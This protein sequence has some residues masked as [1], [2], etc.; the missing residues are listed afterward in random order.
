MLVPT[1]VHAARLLLLVRPPTGGVSV[2]A[3]A[4]PPKPGA[5]ALGSVRR[6]GSNSGKHTGAAKALPW[7]A[8]A[9]GLA[10][11]AGLIYQA[12][13]PAEHGAAPTPTP[14]PS[15]NPS[16]NPNMT[17]ARGL[18]PASQDTTQPSQDTP[19]APA[20]AALGTGA[21]SGTA[22]TSALANAGITRPYI[23]VAVP[24][25]S[26]QP[27]PAPA[28]TRR[29]AAPVRPFQ[30]VSDPLK[31][32]Q[33]AA[34]AQAAQAMTAAPAAPQAKRLGF[35]L[36][37]GAPAAPQAA[38]APPVPQPAAT[39]AQ[40][41]APGF[42]A[43]TPAPAAAAPAAQ[44]ISPP[45]GFAGQELTQAPVGMGERFMAGL[46]QGFGG[47]LL[48]G[49]TDYLNTHRVPDVQP[50]DPGTGQ[51]IP[52][53][54]PRQQVQ[55]SITEQRARDADM[56]AWGAGG[57]STLGTIGNAAAGTAGTVLGTLATPETVLGAGLARSAAASGGAA[58][59]TGTAARQSWGVPA[60]VQP[61]KWGQALVP[62]FMA[63]TLRASP[64]VPGWLTPSALAQ[65]IGAAGAVNTAHGAGQAIDTNALK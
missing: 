27:A 18:V 60:W 36:D 42:G 2:P 25:P 30:P 23:P 54:T 3:A 38:A 43:N 9:A 21:A 28:P 15:P 26:A 51:P 61:T 8:G 35:G 5:S 49:V 57:A 65:A 37:G 24:A 56:P 16:P 14:N 10:G 41:A 58:L 53:P 32:A 62:D 7:V 17:L 63:P 4:P 31:A 59:R 47:T 12:T 40:V 55:Q 45:S 64:L 13:R 29:T 1:P 22:G 48:G 50:I 34:A 33:T 44:G 20:P 19:A 39:V 6:P 52:G 46:R 11:L